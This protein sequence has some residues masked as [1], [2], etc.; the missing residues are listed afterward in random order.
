MEIEIVMSPKVDVIVERMIV[1]E[2]AN[3]SQLASD[4]G[5]SATSARKVL[6]GEPVSMAVAIKVTAFLGNTA[7]FK[8]KGL[9]RPLV[10]ANESG[11][12]EQ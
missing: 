1:K 7:Q 12:V 3:T 2:C 9:F 4:A 10:V 11:E 5:I 6:R 8:L